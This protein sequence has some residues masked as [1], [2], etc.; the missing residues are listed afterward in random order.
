MLL[1]TSLF[2]IYFYQN[3]LNR[4]HVCFNYFSRPKVVMRTKAKTVKSYYRYSFE[5]VQ[6][7]L[8]NGKASSLLLTQTMH[9]LIHFYI[10]F[11]LALERVE[12]G[13]LALDYE[14]KSLKT[15][16]K[17]LI[18]QYLYAGVQSF[19]AFCCAIVHCLFKT[20]TF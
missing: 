17:L 5:Q 3:H 18:Y 16:S 14:Q 6:Y 13:K 2:Q 15:S 12:Q 20:N 7:Q 8:I 10:V 19:R 11:M 1:L 4:I 9:D